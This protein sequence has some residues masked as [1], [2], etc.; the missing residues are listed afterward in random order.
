MMMVFTNLFAS[1][2]LQLCHFR[3]NVTFGTGGHLYVLIA[4]QQ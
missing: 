1:I 2:E 3:P 4:I